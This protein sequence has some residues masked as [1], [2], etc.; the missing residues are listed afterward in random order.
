[1]RENASVELVI[2]FNK[3][4]VIFFSLSNDFYKCLIVDSN[5]D[6]FFS[7]DLT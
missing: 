7:L 6:I 5:F 3:L 2:S 4:E 1:M